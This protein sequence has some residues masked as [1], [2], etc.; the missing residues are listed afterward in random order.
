MAFRVAELLQAG[1]QDE[2]VRDEVTA[3]ILQVW[4]HRHSWPDGW[5]PE[6][7]RQQLPWLFASDYEDP[8]EHRS[9]DVQFMRRVAWALTDEYRFWMWAA[10]L[11]TASDDDRWETTLLGHTSWQE[12]QFIRRLNQLGSVPVSGSR[13][14]SPQPHEQV[15]KQELNQLL[16][17]RRALLTEAMQ[18]A[19]SNADRKPKA[20][21]R[22]R[23]RTASK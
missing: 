11:Q 10:R 1:E 3:T 16:R 20:R 2:S 12:R 6:P 22:Q 9:E 4:D 18:L 13:G 23:K 19:E 5:P 14:A 21:K 17:A 8:T 7:A 15:A